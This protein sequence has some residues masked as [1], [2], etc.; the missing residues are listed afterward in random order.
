MP[1]RIFIMPSFTLLL[2]QRKNVIISLINHMNSYILEVEE[3]FMFIKDLKIVHYCISNKLF[4]S[5]HSISR[6]ELEEMFGSCEDLIDNKL[7][8]QCDNRIYIDFLVYEYR[9][10]YKPRYYGS[11]I[12][13]VLFLLVAFFVSH[14]KTT[15]FYR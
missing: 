8:V 5:K 3:T 13:L 2:Y 7:L 14:V 9:Y 1:N 10:K 12:V 15:M 4:D 11:L 6:V